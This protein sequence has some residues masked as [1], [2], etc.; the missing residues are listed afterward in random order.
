MPHAQLVLYG[1]IAQGLALPYSDI[2]LTLIG[3]NC[4]NERETQVFLLDTL[5]KALS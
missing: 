2:D 4:S 3:V 1:S 5:E